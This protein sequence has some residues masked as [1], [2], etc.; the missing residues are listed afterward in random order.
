MLTRNNIAYNLSVSPYRETIPYKDETIT[1][2]F[3]SELYK[4][5]FKEKLNDNRTQIDE[6]LSRRFGVSVKADIIADLR[7]Y[8]NIEKRGFLLIKD[9]V[10]VECRDKITLS[11]VTMT[12]PSFAE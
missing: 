6:S 3:S 2:V 9:G 4:T 10:E 1:F 12:L 7:L 11:G 8:T 5:K